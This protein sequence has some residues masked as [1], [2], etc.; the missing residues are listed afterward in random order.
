MGSDRNKFFLALWVTLLFCSADSVVVAQI[1]GI[2]HYRARLRHR[3]QQPRKQVK[4]APKTNPRVQPAAY[5][6]PIT[7]SPARLYDDEEKRFARRTDIFQLPSE[8]AR[9]SEGLQQ[10]SEPSLLPADSTSHF[11][12]AFNAS[13]KGT[14]ALKFTRP[15]SRQIDDVFGENQVPNQRERR[16]DLPARRPRNIEIEEPSGE[17]DG[18][19]LPPSALDSPSVPDRP[20]KPLMIDDEDLIPGM[21]PNQALPR[22][23]RREKSP[24]ARDTQRREPEGTFDL[25]E[26]SNENYSK[27]R[28]NSS[29]Y[30]PADPRHPNANNGPESWY[31]PGLQPPGA[32]RERN[33]GI[34]HRGRHP[35]AIAFP[36]TPAP[37]G[38]IHENP[39]SY[40]QPGYVTH[41]EHPNASYQPH[42]TAYETGYVSDCTSNCGDSSGWDSGCNSCGTGLVNGCFESMFYLSLF[43]GY[44]N[45][46]PITVSDPFNDF[47]FEMD[48]GFGAGVALGQFQGRNL[49]TEIEFSYRENDLASLTSPTNVAFIAPA[50]DE[51]LLRSYTGMA[52]VMWEFIEFPSDVIKPY[53]GAGFGFVN[54]QAEASL[55]GANAL[56]GIDESDS[57]FGYQAI[58]G[59]NFRASE[60]LDLFAE[61]RYLKAD[62]LQLGNFGFDYETS[63]FFGG[64]RIKF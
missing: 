18:I 56:A 19:V 7:T 21:K 61:Y 34:D 15:F 60:S 47:R 9:Y 64:A 37:G 22:P 39:T 48:D 36:P 6:L 12:P 41:S 54:V 23:G 49:R 13:T 58:G 26:P 32:I 27:D 45:L 20:R 35:G 17:E 28:S 52:N 2:D 40:P 25:V 55:G 57:S 51:A 10:R 3:Q 33:V 8:T 38:Y 50:L 30:D 14:T 53:V 46:T 59:L 11:V 44:T 43:G 42:Q 4:T 63:N 5:Q 31:R 1:S 24:D 62:S 16:P 29:V